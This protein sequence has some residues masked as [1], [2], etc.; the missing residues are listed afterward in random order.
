MVGDYDAVLI[1]DGIVAVELKV[2]SKYDK[3]DEAQRLNEL[4]ATKRLIF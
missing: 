1:V 2:T 4:K 3:R